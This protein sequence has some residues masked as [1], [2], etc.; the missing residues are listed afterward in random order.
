LTGKR[1]TE[2][3]PYLSSALRENFDESLQCGVDFASVKGVWL[4]T[5]PLQE[6]GF[7]FCISQ[8]SWMLLS[9]ATV[10]CLLGQ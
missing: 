5:L 3:F 7:A 8:L 9:Y 2:E 4:T 10:G 1:K 6:H